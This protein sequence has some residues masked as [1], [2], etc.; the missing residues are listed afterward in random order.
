MAFLQQQVHHLILMYTMSSLC[1]WSQHSVK[2]DYICSDVTLT[3]V[4]HERIVLEVLYK[5]RKKWHDIGTGL[6]FNSDDLEEIEDKYHPDNVRCLNEV[7]KR[8]IQR[9]QL[10]RSM[11]CSSLRGNLVQR[12]DVAQ[13]IE[14]RIQS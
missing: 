10:T 1:V 11:V 12:D 6:G 13:E 9:G 8:R 3:K 14:A 2:F 5:A 4:D 7:L